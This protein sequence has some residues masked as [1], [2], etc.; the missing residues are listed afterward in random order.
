MDMNFMHASPK[1]LITSSLI[2]VL[3]IFP[4]GC[5]TTTVKSHNSAFVYIAENGT[6]TYQG[7][8]YTSPNEVSEKLLADGATPSTLITLVPQGSIPSMHLKCIS[9]DFGKK[10]LSHVVIRDQKKVS[11]SIQQ[12]GSGIQAQPPASAPTFKH[13]GRK[14]R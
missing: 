6:I 7:N 13:H 11:A 2:A 14:R 4:I 5:M 8:I 3:A 9:N 10:G 1:L 12:K